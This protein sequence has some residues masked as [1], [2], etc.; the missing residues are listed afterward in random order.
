MTSCLL[1]SCDGWLDVDPALEIR[2]TSIFET[3]QGFKD[4]LTGVYIRMATAE[5]YGRNTTMSLP[6]LMSQHWTAGHMAG[7][8]PALVANFDFTKESSKQLL[9]TVW[10][11]YYQCIVNLNA[12]LAAMEEKRELFLADNFDLIRGEALGLRAFLH[13]E[14]LRY[15][16][17]AP[18]QIAESMDMNAIPYVT[19]E[20]KDPEQLIS[21]TY[22]E[23][24]ASIL[25]D[26]TDAERLLADD[27]ILRFEPTVLNTPS[28][29]NTLAI[30]DEFHYYRYLKFNILAVR[31]TLARYYMWQ[32]DK[33]KA[34]DYARQVIGATQSATG[35][36]VLTLGNESSYTANALLTFPSEMIFAASN[37]GATATLTPTFLTWA[38]MYTQNATRLGQAFESTLHTSDVRYRSNRLF[39]TRDG[40][41][42]FKK[43]NTAQTTF[44]DDVPIIRLAEMYF[45]IIESG[46]TS[47]F[48]EY[49]VARGLDSS[50]DGSL[51]SESAIKDRLE[52]EYR[53]DFYGEGQMFFFYKRWGYTSMP[54]P[55]PKAIA[56]DKYQ[57][58][59]PQSQSVF[60]T[61]E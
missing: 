24:L 60:E 34:A 43:Y 2:Q 19:V 59:I 18:V 35:Q 47:L 11:Q 58:P 6:E 32:G 7:D 54:W 25:R 28:A 57:L 36:P 4:V 44:T 61:L 26:L 13:F 3:E 16:G 42:Y 53:K 39:E 17:V 40:Y 31:A 5:L 48:R 41:N 37:S 10:M 45:I 15:W 55:T 27:P 56:V 23:V 21:S 22:R 29:D 12:M 14:V 30:G 8:M 38:S 51:T 1:S 33:T 9:E 52:K 50:I 49:R 20:T 46:D